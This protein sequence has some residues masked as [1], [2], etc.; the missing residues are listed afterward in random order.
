[1]SAKLKRHWSRKISYGLWSTIGLGLV[2]V[3]VLL[4]MGH[5]DFDNPT[6]ALNPPVDVV[7]A[8]TIL[9]VSAVDRGSGLKEIKVILSQGGLSKVVLERTFPPGGAKGE[10]V[11]LPVTLQ[12]QALG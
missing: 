11:K 7:G 9:T 5:L 2:V 12:P 8:K 4:A 10:T 3:L 6:V 1:M